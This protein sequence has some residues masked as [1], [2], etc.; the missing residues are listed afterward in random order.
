VT[1]FL[2]NFNIKYITMKRNIYILAFL[3]SQVVINAQAVFWTENFG[4][5]C[6]QGQLVTAYTGTNGVWTHSNTG[7][8]DPSANKWFVSATEAGMGVG[9]CGNG[10]VTNTALVNRTLHMAMD[11]GIAPFIDPGAAYAAGPGANTNKRAQSP[12]INCTGK[13]GIKLSMNY[14]MWGVIN[15][16]FM[17]VNYSAD[18]GVTWSSLGI[19]PQT[20]TVSCSGQ[21]IWT[22]HTVNLP[23]SANNNATVK[24][25]FRWQNINASGADPSCA[26]DD[27]TLSTAVA[28]VSLVPTFSMQTTICRGDSIMVT[29]NTGTTT[30]TG[31]TWTA[32]P[33]GPIFS[34]V[35][36]NTTYI[37]FNTV[38]TYSITYTAAAG[39]VVASV[40]HTILV[41]PTPT[42]SITSSTLTLCVGSSATLN[43]SGAS[44]Y[45]WT[46]VN[47]TG[48]QIVVTP[49]ANTTYMCIGTASITGCKGNSFV[50]ITVTTC[51]GTGI[52]N[53]TLNENAIK[54]FPNPLKDKM[55]IKVGGIN[56]GDVKVE[57]VDIVGKK[58]YEQSFVTMPA[59]T[60]HTIQLSMIPKG[61]FI[62]NMTISGTPQKPIKLVKE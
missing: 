49:T 9:N 3:I 5:G 37:K 53:L 28:S 21:G 35:N 8:N 31:H 61:I 38:G 56:L 36:T 26:V 24:I 60:E 40:T 20:P 55:T 57:L 14:I 52:N 32:N 46:P 39:T 4:T 41:N 43:A 58:L 34:S 50:T 29:G 54:V 11:L 18:N 7:T 30:A 19:P 1:A 23:A 25:G 10:C 13:T 44:I 62:L 17:E 12:T 47:Q 48:A 42:I 45:S 51:V 6:S 2:Y 15:Q 27:I 33:A 16:D 59:D 22:T